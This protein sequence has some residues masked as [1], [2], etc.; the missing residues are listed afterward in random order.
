VTALTERHDAQ[1]GLLAP[2]T[3][4]PAEY[5][6]L[7]HLL[8]EAARNV[9]RTGDPLLHGAVADLNGGAS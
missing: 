6:A 8:D 7:L 9:R 5:T 3:P 4:S 2:G 1:T